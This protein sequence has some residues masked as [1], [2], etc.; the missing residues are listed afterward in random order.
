MPPPDLKTLIVDDEAPAR[1][2]L[3]EELRDMG[4]V[5]VIGEA[6]DGAQALR[7]IQEL[8]PQL[9]LLD[10]QMPTMDGF[11]V[12][13]RLDGPLPTIIF[14]TAFNRHALR[15]FDV[16]AVDYLLKPV[17]PERL[18][19]A[20]R[21]ARNA[22]RAPLEAARRLARTLGAAQQSATPT[23]PPKIPARRGRACY[24]FE[25]AVI[26]ALEADGDTVWLRSGGLRY[27]ASETLGSLVDRLAPYGLVQVN[28]SAAVNRNC[29]RSLAPLPGRRKL[30]IL[31]DGAQI[32]VS[33]RRA[34]IVARLLG[35]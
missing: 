18:E 24:L 16:G 1:H 30:L 15:A 28:R 35:L 25:P 22:Q 20:V 33:R 14:V 3:R 11:E 19:L 2:V 5:E 23:P 31:D 8:C 26:S 29:I 4:G 6:G 10:I 34:P 13:N 9:V 7:M 12:L 21:R 17:A 32:T 27:M